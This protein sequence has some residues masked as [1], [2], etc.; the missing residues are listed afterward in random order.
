MM[1]D[2]EINGRR[3]AVG[4]LWE[5]LAVAI[6]AIKMSHRKEEY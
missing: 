2:C 4:K 1:A 6:N 5:R 3:T